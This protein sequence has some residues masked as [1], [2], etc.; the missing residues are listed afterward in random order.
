MRELSD[1]NKSIIMACVCVALVIA[2]GITVVFLINSLDG[3]HAL[4]NKKELENKMYATVKEVGDDYVKIA[5]LDDN[6]EIHVNT[7]KKLNEGDF[8]VITYNEDEALSITPNEIE[9]I[10]RNKE[11]LIT[12]TTK[13][14]TTKSV[15]VSTTDKKTT[16]VSTT[17]D[18]T[19]MT[20]KKVSKEVVSED[21]I[22]NFAKASYEETDK[23]KEKTSISEK[24]KKNFVTLID[25]IF[26][27][28]TIKGKTFE[29]LSDK[30][31]A[32]I[33]YYVL[34]IDGKIDNKWPNYKKTIKDKTDD[35]KSKLIAKYMDITTNICDAHSDVCEMVKNDFNLLKKSLGLTWDVI[36]SA[37]SYGYNKTYT[38]LKNWYEVWREK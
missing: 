28:G 27:K 5:S 1:K 16:S 12:P 20:S 10:A 9:V 8:I 15:Y 21:E 26:Y 34:L 29:E 18:K 2:I 11:V 13:S 17:K 25:F 24:V 37:F 3:N 36:K 23:A 14:V 35:L 30:A 4:E 7:D 22:I 38:Y 31:K 19:T 33:I 6:E 32:K